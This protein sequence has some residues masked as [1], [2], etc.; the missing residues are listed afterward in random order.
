MNLK[1]FISQVELLF[2]ED[3]ESA[4][5]YILDRLNNQR[6]K[7]VR[8]INELDENIDSYFSVKRETV[9]SN[10]RELYGD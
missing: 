2:I 4:K 3:E 6:T 1:I 10:I 7:L 5:Q 8:L 9:I